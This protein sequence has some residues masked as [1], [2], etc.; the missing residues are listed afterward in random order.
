MAQLLSGWGRAGFG[1]LA[2]GEGTIPVNVTA[3]AAATTGAPQAGVNAQAIASVPGVVGSV[4]SLSVLVDG[5]ANVTPTG[6]AGTSALGT[7]TTISNNNLSV[8]L[9]TA[10]SSLGSVTVDA[11][12]NVTLDTLT[13]LT[14][15]VGALLVWSKIDE[16][17]TSNFNNITET[18]SPSW[19]DVAA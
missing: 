5:E 19:K 15:S 18:Q 2:F 13:E 14:A 3:P 12:A 11:E 4:G 17:Q 8:T 9:N 1:E 16:N 7:A 10:T 6:Q